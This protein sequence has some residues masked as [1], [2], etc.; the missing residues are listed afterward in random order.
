MLDTLIKKSNY[1]LKYR[2]FTYIFA[3]FT[4]LYLSQ[5]YPHSHTSLPHILGFFFQ[6]Q[7]LRAV[8][9]IIII[10]VSQV[11]FYLAVICCL[12][13]VS[14][15]LLSQYFPQP[16]EGFK[17]TNNND[18]SDDD[19]DN[20]NDSKNGKNN[21]DNKNDN[22]NNNDN[23]NSNDTKNDNKN[24]ND[25]KNGDDS[26]VS[27]TGLND[28]EDEETSVDDTIEDED[29]LKE[30]FKLIK[31]KKEANK[32]SKTISECI[33]LISQLPSDNDDTFRELLQNIAAQRKAYLDM[34][35]GKKEDDV[36]KAKEQ[37]RRMVKFIVEDFLADIDDDYLEDDNNDD[38]D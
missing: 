13:I 20:N 34:I 32:D 25:N 18:V 22:K 14:S 21:N 1:I 9:L 17:D 6:N 11:N 38:E 8:T 30:K 35:K 16:I 19:S 36:E 15:N 31:Q 12:L 7:I 28:D 5:L 37:Y 23:K 24:S 26:I 4:A 10:Y 27:I 33:N 29:S 3:I 2:N